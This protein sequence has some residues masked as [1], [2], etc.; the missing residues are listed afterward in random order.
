VGWQ[1]GAQPSCVGELSRPLLA[2]LA[3]GQDL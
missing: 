1:A 2:I 3:S